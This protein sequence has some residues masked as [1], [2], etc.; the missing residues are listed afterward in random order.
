VDSIALA[1]VLGLSLRSSQIPDRHAV[2]GY[3]LPAPAV[4]SLFVLV[5][6]LADASVVMPC[7][8]TVH[9]DVSVVHL[10]ADSCTSV[11]AR[12]L[13]AA[14]ARRGRCKRSL[15]S[16]HGPAQAFDLLRCSMETYRRF[17][18]PSMRSPRHDGHGAHRRDQRSQSQARTRAAA[19]RLMSIALHR[20]EGLR[21]L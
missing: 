18:T 8:R 9:L 14:I 12:P 6:T 11:T 2:I 10:A 19:L 15:H 5:N 17:T 20:G 7:A 13:G 21:V 1:H 3:S 4:R 16:R